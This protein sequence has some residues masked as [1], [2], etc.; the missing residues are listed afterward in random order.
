MNEFFCWDEKAGKIQPPPVLEEEI[1][2][3]QRLG[4]QSKTV[5]ERIKF[6]HPSSPELAR[7]S[8]VCS[9][10]FLLG[11]R[12]GHGLFKLGVSPHVEEGELDM[13]APQL[14][15]GLGEPTVAAA[16]DG[17]LWSRPFEH[18]AVYLNLG[19]KPARAGGETLQPGDARIDVQA[20][21]GE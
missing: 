10:A 16:R 3:L 18:G 8:R 7:V 12:P 2:L 4:A 15:A 14:G 19:A 21:A 17:D 1:G 9:A 20:T 13:Q 5:L 6:E 11:Y